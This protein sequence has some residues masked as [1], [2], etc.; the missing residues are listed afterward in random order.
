MSHNSTSHPLESGPVAA[1]TNTLGTSPNSTDAAP[2]FPP[3]SPSYSLQK[4]ATSPRLFTS[5]AHA[6]RASDIL[7]LRKTASLPRICDAP[8][9]AELPVNPAASDIMTEEELQQAKAEEEERQRKAEQE[10]QRLLE[11]AASTKE[12]EKREGEIRGNSLNG[13]RTT[14]GRWVKG[15]AESSAFFAT[16][17]HSPLKSAGTATPFTAPD[18]LSL[19]R[20]D[21]L[22]IP[23][24]ASFALP[25]HKCATS[26]RSQTN[27]GHAR[28]ASDTTAFQK[29][30][31]SPHLTNTATAAQ[32]RRASITTA[33]QKCPSSPHT[34]TAA[35]AQARRASD[36]LAFLKFAT[37]PRRAS[38]YTPNTPPT[39]SSNSPPRTALSASTGSPKRPSSRRFSQS[40]LTASTYTES[41]TGSPATLT[42]WLSGSSRPSASPP[43]NTPSALTR[44]LR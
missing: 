5:P 22:P 17:P 40:P 19:H 8:H 21:T 41:G 31:S 3:P 24:Q 23:R 30:P 28:R 11:E 13:L 20:C 35:A 18:M 43:A 9:S 44:L 25:L 15:S 27:A 6:R 12:D 2:V 42:R 33:F 36:T 4:C 34:N 37:S 1:F 38:D 39:H 10:W 26:P 32:A 29:C 7:D 16:P 14:S